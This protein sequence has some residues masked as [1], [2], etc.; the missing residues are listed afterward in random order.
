M[1]QSSVESRLRNMG[2]ARPTPKDRRVRD[3]QERRMGRSLRRL[4][5]GSFGRLNGDDL[6]DAYVV[7]CNG[8]TARR[9]G[10]RLVRQG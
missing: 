4:C 1:A 10:D 5:G 8:R 7:G 3:E 9:R 6:W 2:L